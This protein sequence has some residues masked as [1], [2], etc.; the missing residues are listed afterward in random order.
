MKDY[1]ASRTSLRLVR[2][3]EEN[4]QTLQGK[5]NKALAK[6]GLVG[7]IGSVAGVNPTP[8]SKL[9]DL[10]LTFGV[11]VKEN[12]AINRDKRIVVA[13]V[14]D[15]EERLALAAGAV[16]VS[17]IIH[18]IVDNKDYVLVTHGI[19]NPA[20][21]ARLLTATEALELIIRALHFQN[22]TTSTTICFNGFDE[23]NSPSDCQANFDV[24]VKL[25]PQEVP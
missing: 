23:H 9:I 2:F 13:T 7:I 20:S 8:E 21:W 12:V 10:E 17:N 11:R 1:L 14:A 18:Q 19:S 24:R 3:V 5:V 22:P 16:S 25:D 4:D 6:L 15:E